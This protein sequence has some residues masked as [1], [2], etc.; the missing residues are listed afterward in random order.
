MGNVLLIS[1]LWC[2][3]RIP[4][5]TSNRVC[6]NVHVSLAHVMTKAIQVKVTE[7]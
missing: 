3:E 4:M 1:K 6:N 5:S 7:N 2:V